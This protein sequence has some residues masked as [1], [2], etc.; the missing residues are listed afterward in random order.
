MKE[1]IILC[2]ALIL[3]FISQLLM[4]FG[5]S[6][7]MSQQ[8]IDYAHWSLL[9]A[10]LMMLVL[11]QVFPDNAT[12]IPG[13]I[14][15]SIGVAGIIGMCTLDILLWA[16]HSNPQLKAELLKNMM[17]YPSI[18]IPF[19]I[20][21]PSLFYGGLS[22]A[23]YALIKR[24]SW[25]VLILNAGALMIGLGHMILQNRIFPVIGSLFLFVSVLSIVIANKNSSVKT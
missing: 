3:I 2:A 12:K 18:R 14:L 17:A 20:V 1:I 22:I 15:M 7:L 6:F 11:W 23:S 19:L 8:P 9:I 4:S 24:F 13:L 25:Q 10:S 5:Y 16:L 21:G